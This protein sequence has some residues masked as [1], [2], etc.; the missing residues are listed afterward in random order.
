M[1]AEL[2]KPRNVAEGWHGR[3]LNRELRWLFVALGVLVALA[4]VIVLVVVIFDATQSEDATRAEITCAELVQNNISWSYRPEDRTWTEAALHLL[5]HG[6]TKP[7]QPLLCFDQVLHGR[8]NWGAGD[9]WRWRDAATL[10]AG[11]DD[12]QARIACFSDQISAGASRRAA[13][14]ACT[15]ARSSAPIESSEQISCAAFIE[16][17]IAWSASAG[18]TWNSDYLKKLC[19]E[20]SAPTQPG[21]CFNRVMR[22]GLDWGGGTTWQW[23]NA[24]DLCAGTNDAEERIQCFRVQLTER[25]DWRAAIN[26]CNPNR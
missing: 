7:A 22:G 23:A 9:S 20:T 19:G 6:T 12:A 15:L 26:T 2:P 13:T 1:N 5:C 16:G 18:A 11:T 21:L 4:L 24:I 10:C 25:G 14:Q 17:N 3:T 8:L